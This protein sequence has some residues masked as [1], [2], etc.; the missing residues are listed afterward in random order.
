M[1][2]KSIIKSSLE[3]KSH[4]IKKAEVVL[5]VLMVSLDKWKGRKLPCGKCGTKSK[6]R[7][8]LKPR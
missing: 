2:L 8:R 6:V 1:P 4:V 5:G 7:D 3:I